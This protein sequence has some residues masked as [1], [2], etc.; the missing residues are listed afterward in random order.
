MHRRPTTNH[1]KPKDIRRTLGRL[2]KYMIYEKWLMLLVVLF[3]IISSLA[4]VVGT[5]Y[6]KPLINNDIVPLIGQ[7]LD[8]LSLAPMIRTLTV[9]GIIY[10]I[11]AV[12]AFLYNRFMVVVANHTL[13]AVRKDLF[14]RLQDLPIKYFDTHTHGEL[15]SRF[16]N[17]ADTLREAMTNGVTQLLAS[18]V[19]VVGTFAMM[20]VISPVLTILIVVM[21]MIMFRV[22]KFIGGRSAES[23]KKQQKNIGALNGYVEEM[24]GGQ[25]VV[26][27]FCHESVAK[28]EFDERNENLRLASTSANMYASIIMPIMG[29]LSYLNYALTATFGALLV[30]SG[31]LSIGS[32]AS[33]LQYTRSF[34]QP[35]TQISQQFNSFLAALAGA[36]RI[37]EVIDENPETDE[38]YVMLVNAKEDSEGNLTECEECTEIWA[39]KH[40]H[41]DGSVTYTKLNGDV[42]FEN[43]TFSYDGKVEVLKDVSLYAKPGQKIAFVGSTGAGKTTITNLINR[44]YDIN[45]GKIRYDGINIEKIKKDDLRRSL[46]MVLQDTH[47]FTGTVRDNIR[48]GKLD[49]TDEE[50]VAAAKLANANYF[51]EHLPQGYDTLL[52][53]DGA[54]LSQ[55]QRQLIAIARAAVANP[56]VLILDEATSS[57]DTRTEALIEKGMNKLMENRTVFVIAHRLSTVR[58]ANAIIVLE[59]G[60][61]IERGDHDDLLRQKGKYYQLYTG[62]FELS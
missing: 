48:Y 61:I 19:S 60:E 6:L 32:I 37:F 24:I 55:G 35:I 44:F 8:V 59:N 18:S 46:A 58:N 12:A 42:Q 17:D 54:N 22:I 2:I 36:E 33:Y 5:Y 23:Y 52:L 56:P 39:W 53:S 3:V 25:K 57:I 34:S 49:A 15:M 40:P 14:D 4:G 62:Q 29:N 31:K 38:G 28:T 26:K 9:M 16:T 13:Y 21:L 7:P 41:Q 43:V 20:L 50:I 1:Q 11:G 47:L 10:L 51:I 30:I 45:K 27:V